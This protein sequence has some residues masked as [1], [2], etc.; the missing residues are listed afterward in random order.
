[1][2][3]IR[4]AHTIPVNPPGVTPVLTEAQLFKGFQRKIRRPMDFV[5]AIAKCEVLTDENGVV[6]RHV[7]FKPPPGD[8]GTSGQLKEAVE[9]CTEL[10]PH[11]VDYKVDDGSTVSNIISAGSSG[12]LEDLYVTYSF[13][14]QYPNLEVG[15]ADYNKAE[16]EHKRVC[17]TCA[18]ASIIAP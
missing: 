16:A 13:E 2:P 7:T 17:L 9:I 4:L 18:G 15:S 3:T 6:K 5:P 11:R 12:K 10:P 8:D 14:W 1:M